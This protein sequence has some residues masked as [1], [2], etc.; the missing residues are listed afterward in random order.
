MKRLAALSFVAI[1]AIA[2]GGGDDTDDTL[3]RVE[4][5]CHEWAIRACNDTVVDVCSATQEGCITSQRAVC[6]ARIPTGKYTPNGAEECLKSVENAYRDAQLDATE[7]DTV[8]FLGPPCHRILSGSGGPGDACTADG[9]CSTEAGLTC[10]LRAGSEG[11]CQEAEI[12]G[13][14]RACREPHLVCEDDFYCNGSNCVERA[15]EGDDCSP[16]VPCALAFKCERPDGSPPGPEDT[17]ATCIPRLAVGGQ[18]TQDDDCTSRICAM[19]VGATTGVC[20][21]RIVLSTTDPLCGDLR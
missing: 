12:V 10:V 3:A 5:F 13:G 6:E 9:D 4:G 8:L 18:C 21:N 11:T 2:C 16:A 20:A 7:R 14:G 1:S 17:D 15:A 19:A